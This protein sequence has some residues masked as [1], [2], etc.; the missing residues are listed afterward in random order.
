MLTRF[1]NGEQKGSVFYVT[2][3]YPRVQCYLKI[4]I[5][6]AIMRRFSGTR[7]KNYETRETVGYLLRPL[8]TVGSEQSF[9]SLDVEDKNKLVK[10]SLFPFLGGILNHFKKTTP[11]QTRFLVDSSELRDYHSTAM[12]EIRR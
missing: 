7:T 4:L 8:E 3:K 5:R 12:S 6:L 11:V 9:F 10:Q 1:R 2:M